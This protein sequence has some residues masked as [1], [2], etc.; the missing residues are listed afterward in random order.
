VDRNFED[1]GY[2]ENYGAQTMVDY[3][4]SLNGGDSPIRRRN[5]VPI[6]LMLEFGEPDE[7]RPAG[8]G[9]E[10]QWYVIP[11]VLLN[12]RQARA[13]SARDELDTLVR[14]LNGKLIELPLPASTATVPLN[15]ILSN[16]AVDS[17]GARCDTML[18]RDRRLQLLL[19]ILKAS[20]GK[21]G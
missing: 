15:W 10:R 17:I 1:G 12:I 14:S 16:R 6:V 2:V 13:H 9:F 8:K 7:G 19:D 4:R 3:L 21:G 20:P 18:G 5:I 11:E